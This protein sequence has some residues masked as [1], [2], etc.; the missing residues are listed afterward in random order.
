MNNSDP[1]SGTLLGTN[2]LKQM[3]GFINE[4]DKA[5]DFE[6]WSFDHLLDRRQSEWPFGIRADERLML[7]SYP[8][9]VAK[10]RYQFGW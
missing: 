6:R 1:K 8:L 5:R 10:L 3:F 2:S 7:Q 9:T 4:I